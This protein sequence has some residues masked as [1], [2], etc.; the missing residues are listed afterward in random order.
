MVLGREKEF[1]YTMDKI[2]VKISGKID[3]IDDNGESLG[4]VDYKT[5]RKKEKANKNI[6]MAL[7]TEAILNDAVNGIS[8]T[9]GEASLHFLRFG[10]DPL[11]SHRFSDEE[12]E[13]YRQKIK[14]VA[15]GIRSG[16]FQT[17]K[18][19]YNCQYCDYK[20]FLCPAWEE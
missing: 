14:D 13:E 4:I 18:D 1:S 8:G 6:Q 19:N 12:L 2:N 17:K 5:S 3:R 15:S 10:D 11:S 20:A 16:S 7:Y 9:P